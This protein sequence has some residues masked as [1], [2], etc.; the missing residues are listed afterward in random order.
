MGGFRKGRVGVCDTALVRTNT[1]NLQVVL[2]PQSNLHV[3][4][5]LQLNLHVVQSL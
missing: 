2:S 1:E 4:Q 3:V 5:S